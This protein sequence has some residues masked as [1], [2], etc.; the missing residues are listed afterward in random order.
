MLEDV[1]RGVREY[2]SDKFMSPLGASMT[3]SWCA[4]NYKFLLVIFSSDTAIRKIHLIN[5]IYQDGLYAWGHLVW[6]PL[7]TALIYIFLYPFPSNWVYSYSLR[8]RMEAL[9]LKR[10]V[11][12]QT[13]LTHE[14]SQALRKKFTDI[15]LHNTAET[16]RL[17]NTIDSLRDQ[18]RLSIEEKNALTEEYNLVQAQ[19]AG[20]PPQGEDLAGT[21]QPKRE[22]A[23]KYPGGLS[24]VQWQLIDS[25]GRYDGPMPLGVLSAKLSI[26][27]QAAWFAA[28][29]LSAMGY[30]DPRVSIDQEGRDE[31][32]VTLTPDG[33]RLFMSTLE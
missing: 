12:N 25:V 18:L 17:A 27:A 23:S 2:I 20:R 19:L 5:L 33:L 21:D 32:Y 16:L 8:R 24:K 11:E 22:D 15:E 31:R 1:V 3:A 4:W 30:A 14:E 7:A 13:V 10:T 6:G 29:E 26:G 28:D 9:D